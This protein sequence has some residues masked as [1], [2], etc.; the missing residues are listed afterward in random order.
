MPDETFTGKGF[1][2][3]LN[4]PFPFFE[5]PG[6]R[7][8]VPFLFSLFIYVFLMVFQLLFAANGFPRYFQSR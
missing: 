1:I 7:I 5:S 8:L 6:Q 3:K 4:R 2:E